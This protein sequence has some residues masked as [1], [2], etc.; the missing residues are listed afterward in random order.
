M[1]VNL[2]PLVQRR[3]SQVDCGNAY[4]VPYFS[5]DGI[6]SVTAEQWERMRAKWHHVHSLT[7]VWSE[8]AV[9]GDERLKDNKAKIAHANQKPLRL[10]ERIITASSDAEDIVWEPF[11]GLCSATVASL[12]THRRCFSAEINADYYELARTRLLQ[13]GADSLWDI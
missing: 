2:Y 5:F 10:I 1:Y 9:R 13:E 4:L 11:G 12:K 3:Y 8:P 6:L 7:N